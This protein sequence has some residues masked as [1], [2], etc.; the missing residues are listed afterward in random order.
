MVFLIS[1]RVISIK[2]KLWG[3]SSFPLYTHAPIYKKHYSTSHSDLYVFRF[4][5]VRCFCPD[6]YRVL[7]PAHAYHSVFRHD[8]RP[9][10]KMVPE[11]GW[12]ADA[13]RQTIAQMQKTRA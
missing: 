5:S 10:V 1:I 3:I 8:Y 11:G 6:V 2:P 7:T 12:C 13:S 9:H 4:V